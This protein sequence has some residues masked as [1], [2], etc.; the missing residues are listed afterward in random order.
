MT[1]MVGRDGAAARLRAGLLLLVVVG[2]VGTSLAL[3]YD[4]HWLSPWQFAPWMTLGIVIVATSALA[5]R[6]TAATVRL[7]RV[8]AVVTMVSALL[9]AWQHIAANLNPDSHDHQHEDRR[10]SMTSAQD[11]DHHEETEG[12]GHHHDEGKADDHHAHGDEGAADD[13]HHADDEK[14]SASAAH[15]STEEESPPPSLLDVVIGAVGH[16][17]IPAALSLAPIGLALGLATL[18]LGGSRNAS[19]D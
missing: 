17:P 18:G 13:H 4:R 2:V 6:Q 7:A 3:A 12:D 5:V 9:G 8:V 19:K 1:D 15:D 16:A 14:R 10:E 11:S